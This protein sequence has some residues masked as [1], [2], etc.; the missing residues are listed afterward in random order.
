MAIKREKKLVDYQTKI[1]VTRGAGISTAANNAAREA[2]I[3]DQIL[4]RQADANLKRLKERGHKLG[5]DKAYETSFDSMPQEVEIDGVKR[6]INVPVKPPPPLGMGKTESE[7]Y[8][9]NIVNLFNNKLRTDIDSE[10]IKA[11]QEALSNH[12]TPDMYDKN[13]DNILA[14]YFESMADGPHEEI[15]KSYAQERKD[16]HGYKVFTNYRSDLADNSIA[17]YTVNR[18][19]LTQKMNNRYRTGNA[20][21]EEYVRELKGYRDGLSTGGVNT[22]KYE[23]ADKAMIEGYR[24][25]GEFW[26]EY[27]ILKNAS[28]ISK[29]H[30]LVKDET[31]EITLSDGRKVVK[32]NLL[33]YLDNPETAKLLSRDLK[34]LNIFN[35]ETYIDTKVREQMGT[36]F[37]KGITAVLN[38]QRYSSSIASDV[39]LF[40]K[41]YDTKPAYWNQILDSQ[42]EL[43][44]EKP[45]PLRRYEVMLKAHGFAPLLVRQSMRS[46]LI[47]PSKESLQDVIGFLSVTSDHK[48]NNSEYRLEG[49][50]AKES[51]QLNYVA[52][53]YKSSGNDIETTFE[54]Y[55]SLKDKL[56]QSGDISNEIQKNLMTSTSILNRKDLRNFVVQDLQNGE[57]LRGLGAYSVD[58]D[59]VTEVIREVEIMVLTNNQVVL[60]EDQYNEII[61]K[62]ANQVLAYKGYSVSGSTAP[63][64]VANEFVYSDTDQ[65]MQRKRIVK[66]GAEENYG[67]YPQGIDVTQKE[68]GKSI[69]YIHQTIIDKIKKVDAES[70]DGFED[71]DVFALIQFLESKKGTDE[72]FYNNES[73]DLH[74][75]L[76]PES[77]N[78]LRGQT[79]EYHIGLFNPGGGDYIPLQNGNTPVFLKIT[80]DEFEKEKEKYKTEL[81]EG[82]NKIMEESKQ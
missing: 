16:V 4:N 8:E 15:M 51:R 38:G 60:E 75:N 78:Y 2:Q 31:N 1:G 40:E 66:Y 59:F 6:T 63:R 7:Q 55:D 44:G 23:L 5:T 42:I 12:A 54:I 14:P 25:G 30:R 52:Q 17:S 70:L 18:N 80:R 69:S 22:K 46:F 68:S 58:D 20:D 76:I 33:K 65:N 73:T 36:D 64:F 71:S 3:F 48:I 13:V 53:I 9:K 49:F 28:D 82:R 45:T 61:A 35:N 47:N 39:K 43:A 74:I 32:E 77:D 57:I 11:S 29:I 34:A 10:I 62:A 24:L 56:D 79:P 19:N 21:Y 41:F 50:N 67:I 81:T 37:G 27:P 72:F 26:K